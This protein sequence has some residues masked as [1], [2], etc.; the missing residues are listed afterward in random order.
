MGLLASV[1]GRPLEDTGN[2]VPR[3]MVATEALLRDRT[4]RI[5]RPLPSLHATQD[6]NDLSEHR[7]VVSQNGLVGAILRQ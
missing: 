5:G 6:R 7:G 2:S 3:E 1:P 4:R